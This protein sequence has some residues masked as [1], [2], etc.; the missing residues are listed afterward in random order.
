MVAPGGRILAI[1]TVL[2]LKGGV[3]KTTTCHHLA[4][5]LALMGKRVLLV[6][7]DPQA[8]LT[9]GFIGPAATRAINPANTL[10]AVY[11]G[12]E[13][14]P[15]QVIRPA[16]VPGIDLLPG[17]YVAADFNIPRPFEAPFELQACLREFLAEVSAGYDLVFIDC[18]PTL[19]LCSWAALV[20]S[21]FLVTPLKPED[22]GAQGIAFVR[23]S[24]ALVQSG[25]NPS[26][27]MLGFLLTLMTPR[28]A[29]H[30][31]YEESLR[32][33]YG[34]LVFKTRMVE[35]VD[36]VE[37]LNRRLPV[38]NYKPRGA[39]AKVMRELA[40]ELCER[41]SAAAIGGLSAPDSDPAIGGLS[42][43]AS[44]PP[45]APIGGL[46]VTSPTRTE[47]A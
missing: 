19:S 5:T 29:V 41:L 3:G 36:Y 43:P 10:A 33:E 32:A 13:P 42:A 4:G 12:D 18:P 37:A 34:P 23:D 16:G 1:L 2:N 22:Y 38:A 26:L 20:A 35:A 28:K 11:A 24:M 8:S 27:R 30:Q 9:Q 6:D 14:F 46:S 44:D 39:A 47:A 15:A 7:N 40:E 31:L 25:P 21:D 45:A 17:S